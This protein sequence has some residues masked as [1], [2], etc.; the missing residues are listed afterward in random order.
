MIYPLYLSDS[1]MWA[2]WERPASPLWAQ[3]PSLSGFDYFIPLSPRVMLRLD[4]RPFESRSPQGERRSK[5]YSPWEASLARHV[6]TWG[7][8]SYLYGTGPVVPPDCAVQC[9]AR[10]HNRV[11]KTAITSLGYKPNS[12]RFP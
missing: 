6:I 1:P 3:G 11:I 12:Q 5:D 7:A 9:L 10:I 4:R 8:T 2:R